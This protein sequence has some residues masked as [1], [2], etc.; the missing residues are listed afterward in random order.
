MKA[1]FKKLFNL[2]HTGYQTDFPTWFSRIAVIGIIALPLIYSVLYLWAFWDPYEKVDNLPVA[3]VNLDRG[4]F[5]TS[6]ENPVY[7]NIGLDLQ[8]ELSKKNVLKFDFTSLENAQA[9][10]N[11]KQY[12]AYFVIPENFTQ[13]ILSV[14]SD[15]PKKAQIDVKIREASSVVASKIVDRVAAEIAE[16]LSH[17][18][19]QEYFDNIFIQSRGTVENLQKAVDGA[20]QLSDGLDSAKNGSYTLVNGLDDALDGSKTLTSGLNSA[21][22]GGETIEI[23]LSTAESGANSLKSGL[24][25]LASGAD[26]LT[27]NLKSAQ[28]GAVQI[29]DGIDSAANGAASLS[30]YSQQAASGAQQLS[31]G[32]DASVGGAQSLSN[33]LSGLSAGLTQLGQGAQGVA[34]LANGINQGAQ[35]SVILANDAQNELQ[36]LME[37]YPDLANDPTAQDL[38][39][40][41]ATLSQTQTGVS[42]AATNLSGVASQMQIGAA[43][44]NQGAS[45]LTTGAASLQSGLATLKSGA[46]NLAGGLSQISQGQQQLSSGLNTLKSGSVSLTSGLDSLS[47]GSVKLADNLDTAYAGSRDLV[48]GLNE[49]TNGQ[50]TLVDGLATLNNGGAQLSKGLGDLKDGGEKLS[51]G[52]ETASSGSKELYQKLQDGYNASKDQIDETKTAQKEPVLAN[53]VQMDEQYVEPVKTYG[54]GFTPYFVPLSMW[55]GAMAIFVVFGTISTTQAREY[56]RFHLLL[57]MLRRYTVYM[58]LGVIQ[59]VALGFVL[60]RSLGLQPNHMT[61]FY[62]FIIMMSFLFIAIMMFLNYTFGEAGPFIAVILLMLQLTS[63]G[64]TYPVETSPQFFQTIAPYLP[65]TYAVNTLRDVISGNTIRM[66]GVIQLFGVA[67]VILFLASVLIK[68]VIAWIS[69]PKNISGSKPDRPRRQFNLFPLMSKIKTTLHSTFERTS[70]IKEHRRQLILRLKFP[71][72]N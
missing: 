31:S 67:T 55:V 38:F 4:G 61:Q 21:V 18:I 44:A 11:N 3:F 8:V 71:R 7:R 29:R 42:N 24:G 48:N 1:F 50:E 54:T 43:S 58:I 63:S 26:I 41:L 27:T 72:R 35:S 23:G 51:D 59:S 39:A 9:G 37:T 30:V 25:Q 70:G 64:G 45:Q 69:G 6:K 10:L 53:P 5:E 28:A 22:S 32:L 36:Q 33:G 14:S 60:I 13:N 19:T 47:T 56:K 57:E 68:K 52:L 17:K 46:D 40:K 34:T 20:S 62:E 65:M 2:V 66:D 15:N 49:L 12:Y 16:N